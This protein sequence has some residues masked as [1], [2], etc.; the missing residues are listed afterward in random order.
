M[1]LKARIRSLAVMLVMAMALTAAVPE[2]LP[3]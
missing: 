3:C 2:V 1:K